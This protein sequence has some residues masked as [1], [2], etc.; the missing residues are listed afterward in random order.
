MKRFAAAAIAL[1]CLQSGAVLFPY[2]FSAY[3]GMTG[4]KT[5]GILPAVYIPVSP[6]T[7]IAS[8]Y[9]FAYGFTSNFDVYVNCASLV[10]APTFG[11]S[12]SWIMPRFDLGGNN[13]IGL[14]AFF[15]N[16]ASGVGIRLA[17]QYHLFIEGDLFVFEF[18]VYVT[19]PL[20]TP[21]NTS[22]AL[23]IAPD[24]KVVKDL[25]HLFLEVD[26]SYTIGT[27]RVAL[28]VVPGMCFTF[29]GNAHQIC[30]GVPIGDITSGA[31]TVG[32]NL[33]YAWTIKL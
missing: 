29:S 14:Q 24:F 26:P 12:G 6:N 20:S 25:F 1:L 21:T 32:I 13:I 18:N 27:G 11:Y 10:Y 9:I 28:T 2:S 33:W 5:I 23:C 16:T 7:G 30:V 22:V 19:V 4:E 8:D 17:P 31:V 3:N 15:D